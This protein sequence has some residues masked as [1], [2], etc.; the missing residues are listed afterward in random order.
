MKRALLFCLIFVV[1]VT[2]VAVMAQGPGEG[3]P[4]IEGN[5][6]GSANIGTFNPLRCDNTTCS[7][8]WQLMFPTVIGASLETQYYA[9]VGEDATVAGALATDW[10]ISEDGLT[11]T[12]TLRDDAVWGDGT[13][14]TATDVKFAFE[15]IKS[16]QAETQLYTGTTD[17]SEGNPNGIKEVNIIDDHT[18]EMVFGASVCSALGLA[19]FPVV[20]AHVFG[21]DGSAEFDFTALIDAEFDLAPSVTSGFFKFGAFAPGESIGIV[22]DTEYFEG[23]PLVGGF[24]YRDVPDQT[25][26]VEQFLAGETNLIDGPAVGRRADLRADANVQVYSFPGNAW[27]YVGLNL[28]DPENPQPGLDE[29]GNPIDQGFHPIFGDV[30]VRRA[31]QNGINVP[32]IVQGAVFGEGEQMPSAMIQNSWAYDTELAAI[33]FDQDAAR[34]LLDEAGWVA[35]GDP[36][37]DGGDGQRTCDGCLYAE[38]GAPL[39]FNLQTNQ[40]NTRREAAVVLIQDQLAQLG[41]KVNVEPIDFDTL[42]D[43][44]NSQTYDAFLIGWRN[45]FPDDPDQQQLFGS[46]SDDPVQGLSNSSSYHNPEL[47]DLMAQA[48]SVPGCAP[49]DRAAIYHQIQQIMQDDQ[50]YLFLYTVNGMYAARTDVEGFDPRPNGIFNQV[51]TW[52][53]AAE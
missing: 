53:I 36:L 38:A 33:P 2:P 42:L 10:T 15:A 9:R 1:L 31:L 21:Y 12:F 22:A 34:A 17:W 44:I 41:V 25:V 8:V 37:V 47:N 29:A 48:N 46:A 32:D 13:P 50:P 26:Q 30:R 14:I 23:S 19:G 16:G 20:P 28:A 11:Y 39:E 4:V 49:E 3:A 35:S 43:V 6:G 40:G 27:D 51:Q 7:R 5:F 45:G 24:I 52:V 18:V